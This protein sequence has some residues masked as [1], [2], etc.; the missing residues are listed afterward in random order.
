MKSVY[1]HIPFCKSICSYCDFCKMFYN[2]KWAHEYLVALKEEIEDQYMGE[3]VNTLYIGGGTPSCLSEKNLNYLFK[4]ISL[5]NLKEDCEFTFE[6]N[7]NDINESLLKILKS[8]GVNRLS[9]G[10]E[11]FNEQK[12]VLMGREHT[13]ESAKDKIALARKLGFQ[14]INI[15]LIYGLPNET[16][17][18]LKKDLK[19]IM[20]LKPEHISTYSLILSEHTLLHV[21]K[22]EPINEDLD[23]KFY[24]I[25]GK[26]LKRKK[27]HHYE[28]SNFSK[29]GYESKH[30]LGYWNNLEYYGFGLSAS[31]YIDS[32]RYTNTLNL[33]KYLHREFDGQKELMTPTDVLDNEIMLGLRKLEGINLAEFEKKYGVSLEETYPVTPL[34]KKKELMKKKGYIYINPDKL[35]VMNEILMKLI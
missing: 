28:V 24:K 4:I 31:G 29:K 34:L 16:K 10:I 2:P 13:F 17:K 23:A 25:I 1:I 12:L 27:Y 9:I 22:M 21:N 6:C 15:D 35:Y 14:N 8:G 11:S 33:N 3:E 30:N 26:K 32:I 20:K 18:I 5:L 7:L 19:Q